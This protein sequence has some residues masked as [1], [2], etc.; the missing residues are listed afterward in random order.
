MTDFNYDLDGTCHVSRR[1]RDT[2]T[3]SHLVFMQHAYMLNLLNIHR[4]V[5]D[6]GMIAECNLERDAPRVIRR[7]REYRN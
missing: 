5:I 6:R 1:V 4:S 7:H 2:F 3:R